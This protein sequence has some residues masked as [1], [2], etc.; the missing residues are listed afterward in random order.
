[1]TINLMGLDVK[2]MSSVIAGLGLWLPTASFHLVPMVKRACT[3]CALLRGG[4][5]KLACNRQ[6][7]RTDSVKQYVS[8]TANHHDTVYTLS[9]NTH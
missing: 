4:L 9:V 6:A 7:I 3:S 2:T 5:H 8:S 1:M